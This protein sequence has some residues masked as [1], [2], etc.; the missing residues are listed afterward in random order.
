MSSVNGE[1][2][3]GDGRPAMSP[4]V[5][6]LLATID[7]TIASV[8]GVASAADGGLV[9]PLE[10]WIPAV[11][12]AGARFAATVELAIAAVTWRWPRS[13][14]ALGFAILPDTV[15]SSS[16]KLNAEPASCR[17]AMFAETLSPPP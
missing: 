6:P 3:D 5:A 15:E 13:P 10:T 9:G 7:D 8:G 1:G 14:P 16:R 4:A 2:M 11:L 17:P 12:A